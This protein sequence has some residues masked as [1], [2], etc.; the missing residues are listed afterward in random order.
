MLIKYTSK[1]ASH[2]TG[3]QPC[4]G[5]AFHPGGVAVLQKSGFNSIQSVPKFVQH[6][7]PG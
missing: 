5:L 4:D 2:L 3:R 7:N 1:G 6:L